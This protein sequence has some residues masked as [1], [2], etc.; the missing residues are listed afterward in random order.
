MLLSQFAV[1]LGL[2]FVGSPWVFGAL[3]CYILRR[4]SGGFGPIYNHKG[5]PGI[6][7]KLQGTT[8]DHRNAV[9]TNYGPGVGW[10]EDRNT[11]HWLE[12]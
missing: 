5:R 6:V 1:F 11:T 2:G 10:T 8:T 7:C 9:A 12:N 4:Y 3:V